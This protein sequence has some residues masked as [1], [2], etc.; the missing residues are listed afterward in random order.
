MR[1]A[2]W[3]RN[4]APRAPV[5]SSMTV[6]SRSPAMRVSSFI[7]AGWPKAC[8]T[9]AAAVR[10]PMARASPRT[11]S[12]PVSASTSPGITRHPAAPAASAA[13]R[14][15]RHGTMT[16][17]RVPPA[18]VPSAARSAEAYASWASANAT[19]EAAGRSSTAA[20]AASSAATGWSSVAGAT[21]GAAG[22]GWSRRGLPPSM[23]RV[24][25]ASVVMLPLV[26]VECARCR[27]EAESRR[28]VRSAATSYT[29]RRAIS[30]PAPPPR[31]AGRF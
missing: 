7:T 31:H 6:T 24:A 23:A 29:D 28:G 20:S 9:K 19:T 17:S 1:P 13:T 3:P 5:M 25:G 14:S 15:P 26:R 8:P 30:E 11:E 2:G 12:A 22:H 16:S 21:S 18:A 27:R 10:S 4:E